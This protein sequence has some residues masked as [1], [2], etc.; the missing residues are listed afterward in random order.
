M[1]AQLIFIPLTS[2][3]SK[4]DLQQPQSNENKGSSAAGAATGGSTA[5]PGRTAR[6]SRGKRPKFPPHIPLPIGAVKVFGQNANHLGDFDSISSLFNSLHE[7]GMVAKL[8]GGSNTVFATVKDW[9][10]LEKTA[11]H[12]ELARLPSELTI[13]VGPKPT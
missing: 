8:P 7:G 5:Q 12:H 10:G 2:S 6:I 13:V 3:Q 4:Q 9:S 11:V 1:P